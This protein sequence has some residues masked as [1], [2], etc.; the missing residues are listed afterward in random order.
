[1]GLARSA[2]RIGRLGSASRD[3]THPFLESFIIIQKLF[4]RKNP[5]TSSRFVCPIGDDFDNASDTNSA[6]TS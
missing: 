2:S 1:M 6:R 4:E 5:A 3:K